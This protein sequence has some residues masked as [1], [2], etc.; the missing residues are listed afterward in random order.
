MVG[1]GYL[2]YDLLRQA[3]WYACSNYKYFRWGSSPAIL[4]E[5]DASRSP[6]ERTLPEPGGSSV[7]DNCPAGQGETFFKPSEKQRGGASSKFGEANTS[8]AL[9]RYTEH[10][11][12]AVAD[13]H[14]ESYGLRSGVVLVTALCC[15][16]QPFGF[17]KPAFE[18]RRP[19][20]MHWVLFEC[21]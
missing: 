3:K 21:K 11:T 9:I 19:G 13:A 12:F 18:A 1:L 17:S 14:K 10:T 7:P 16:L 20:G 2:E 15:K 5:W 6:E 4:P 8:E